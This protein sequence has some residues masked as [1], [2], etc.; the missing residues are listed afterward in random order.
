MKG[1]FSKMFA[2]INARIRPVVPEYIADGFVLVDGDKIAAVGNMADFQAP[3]G[4]EIIDAGHAWLLP[5][6]VDSHC[7]LGL[8]EIG[9]RGSNAN[10]MGSPFT[11]LVNALDAVVPDEEYMFRAHQQAGITTVL[12]SPGSANVFGGIAVAIK[13]IPCADVEDIVLKNPCLM[14]MAL[15]ENPARVYGSS[16]KMPSTKMGVAALIREKFSQARA[17]KKKKALHFDNPDKKPEEFDKKPELEVLCDIL[18][19]KL[20]VQIHAHNS[21]DMMTAIRLQREFGFKMHFTHGT[22]AFKIIPQLKKYGVGV[23]FSPLLS[24]A[25]KNENIYRTRRVL[26]SMADNDLPFAISTDFPVYPI[27]LLPIDAGLAIKEG[28]S[29]WQAER[30]ITLQAA[31]LLYLADRVGSIEPGKDADLVL[32]NEHPLLSLQAAPQQVFIN[33]KLLFAGQTDPRQHLHYI[34]AWESLGE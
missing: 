8:D 25:G 7:H 29:L 6:F 20:P 33:G 24:V 31:E 2:I 4:T 10:E 19:G 23:S 16:G 13:T 12:T 1:S 15:G 11:P 27:E 28:L 21:E 30:A 18:D 3:E 14:K 17:Y 32:W 26:K 9:G 22:E 5:G 34:K